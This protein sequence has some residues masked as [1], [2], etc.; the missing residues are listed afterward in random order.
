MF[1]RDGEINLE[2]TV[3]HMADLSEGRYGANT[4]ERFDWTE[5]TTNL[6]KTLYLVNQNSIVD[7]QKRRGRKEFPEDWESNIADT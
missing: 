2:R 3:C 7:P 1:S 5:G 6:T 4:A